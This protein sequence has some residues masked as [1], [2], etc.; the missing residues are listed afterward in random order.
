MSIIFQYPIPNSDQK[1]DS[2][3][4][5]DLKSVTTAAT[6]G[7][8]VIPG[9][10]FFDTTTTGALVVAMSYSNVSMTTLSH[11]G[12]VAVAAGAATTDS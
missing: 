12:Y 10:S 9:V 1:L 4:G 11:A 2:I 7:A 5:R 3:N 8:G 6:I